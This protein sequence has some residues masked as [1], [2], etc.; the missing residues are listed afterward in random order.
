MIWIF[1]LY[2][3]IFHLIYYTRVFEKKFP[4]LWGEN[5]SWLLLVMSHLLHVMM[6]T[7]ISYIICRIFSPSVALDKSWGSLLLI[8]QYVF[9]SSSINYKVI[10]VV[11]IVSCKNVRSPA[12]IMI[13]IICCLFSIH[14]E[15]PL[16]W[17]VVTLLASPRRAAVKQ[18]L[19]FGRCWYTLW[20]R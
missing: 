10:L 12:L 2:I 14:R 15:F 4:P 19:F 5:C 16:L 11:Y 1:F 9:T 6:G 7:T 17:A 20:T 3:L 13:K 8:S 18:Q